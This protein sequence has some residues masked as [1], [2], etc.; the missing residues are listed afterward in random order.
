MCEQLALARTRR[1][2]DL[3][4]R[5]QRS[6]PEIVCP[7]EAW[8]TEVE[9]EQRDDTYEHRMWVT[10]PTQYCAGPMVQPKPE[11]CGEGTNNPECDQV[12]DGD[13]LVHDE[14]RFGVIGE[15]GSSFRLYLGAGLATNGF[16]CALSGWSVADADLVTTGSSTSGSW[17]ATGMSNGTVEVGFAGGCLWA[18]NTD[19][20]PELEALLVGASLRFT[21]S[22]TGDRK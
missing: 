12:C 11:D 20:D 14:E 4:D 7:H 17:E 13:V 22:F 6:R 21:T 18:A 10:L 1:H 8:P 3:A 19:M 15:D 5:L 16:N 9:I 2:R